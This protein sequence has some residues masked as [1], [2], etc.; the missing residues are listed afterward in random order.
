MEIFLI[1]AAGFDGAGQAASIRGR[2]SADRRM[3]IRVKARAAGDDL[4]PVPVRLAGAGCSVWIRVRAEDQPS[5]VLR[6]L[7]GRRMRGRGS[8]TPGG[9]S[10]EL[11]VRPD[12]R[13]RRIRHK[14]AGASTRRRASR[15]PSGASFVAAGER[16]PSSTA[17]RPERLAGLSGGC[18]HVIRRRPAKPPPTSVRCGVAGGDDFL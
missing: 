15:R 7:R 13:R 5:P 11:S 12:L 18:G 16:S 14:A 10:F 17:G 6:F 4:E 8:A 3:P 1:A 9:F 2:S